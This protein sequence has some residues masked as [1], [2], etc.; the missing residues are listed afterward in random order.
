VPCKEILFDLKTLVESSKENE[1]TLREATRCSSLM[2]IEDYQRCHCKMKYKTNKCT[3]RL[4]GKL[5]NSKCNSSLSR[6]NK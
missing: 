6:E 2:G 5:C 1:I 3:C 4:V